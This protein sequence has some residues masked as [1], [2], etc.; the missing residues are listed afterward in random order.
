VGQVKATIGE[1]VFACV[2]KGN[3]FS[4]SNKEPL[5]QKKLYESFLK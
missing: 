1:T 2:Y 3:I 4:K 5:D